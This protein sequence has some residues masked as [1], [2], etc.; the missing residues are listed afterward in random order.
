MDKNRVGGY[1]LVPYYFSKKGFETWKQS[2]SGRIGDNLETMIIRI[3]RNQAN[4]H[5]HLEEKTIIELYVHFKFTQNH[6]SQK[7]S[8]KI[9]WK[10]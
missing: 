2:A 10:K 8:E 9:K 1:I 6:D 3:I 4:H 7:N 5:H